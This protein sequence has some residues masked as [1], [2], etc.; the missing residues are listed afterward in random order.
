MVVHALG[1]RQLPGRRRGAQHRLQRRLGDGGVAGG[2]GRRVRP[3]PAQALARRSRSSPTPSSTTTRPTPRS[4]TSTTRSARSSR[5]AAQQVVPE[6]LVR[7]AADRRLRRRA[8]LTRAARPSTSTA[9]GRR[10]PVPGAHNARNAGAALTAIKLAGGDVAARRRGAG[11]LRGRRPPLRAPR[12]DGQRRA[13]GRRLRPPPDRGAGDDRGRAHARTPPRRRLLPAAPVLAHAARGAARSARRS[14]WPTSRSSS[15]SIRRASARRTSRASPA[16]SSPRRPPTP[17][18]ANASPGCAPTRPRRRSCATN[19]AAGD[20]LLTMGAGDVDSRRAGAHIEGTGGTGSKL[21]A[22]GRPDRHPPWPAPP[23]PRPRAHPR[24]RAR[25]R[26][27]DVAA[28]SSFVAVRDVQIT[29]V[30]ASDGEQVKAALEGAALEMTTLHVAPQDCSR[31]ATANLTSVGSLKVSH[32]L[33]ARAHDPG[34]RAPAGG[35]ARARGR[36]SGSRS[37]ATGVVLRG[38]TAERD[39]PSLVARRRRRSGPK[40]TDRRALRALT[41]AGAAPDELLRRSQR[42]RQSASRASS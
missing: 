42:A 37:R 24:A 21:C 15:T 13:G 12:H 17:A 6:D 8:Q 39:L 16:C 28:R 32:R 29:G 34:D 7:L 1:R 36:A 27:L 4:A 5:S 35:R 30:T 31:Q 2:R 38:V 25:G 41:I 26:R 20:L 33:P 11:E 22:N 10:S 18:A 9:R 3:Q 23:A 19:C 40:L 14:R